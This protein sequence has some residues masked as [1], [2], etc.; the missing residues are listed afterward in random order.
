[1][2]DLSKA[3]ADIHREIVERLN[4]PPFSKNYSL[5]CFLR[6]LCYQVVFD[7][8]VG[9][10]LLELLNEVYFDK[11]CQQVL[12]TLDSNYTVDLKNEQK[13][14]AVTRMMEFLKLLKFRMQGLPEY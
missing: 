9:Q 13:D 3:G 6:C 10:E 7:E 1:M 8:I 11:I 14:I 12:T 2:S 5:V 4:Q